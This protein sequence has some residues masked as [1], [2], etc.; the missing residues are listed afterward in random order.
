MLA[1]TEVAVIVPAAV[2]EPHGKAAQLR[3]LRGEQRADERL[4]DALALDGRLHAA[5]FP[6][7][8]RGPSGVRSS[9]EAQK[10]LSAQ[11]P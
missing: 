8:G 5:R 4:V 3:E 10:R 6:T 9:E 2:D 7:A 1:E 11:P